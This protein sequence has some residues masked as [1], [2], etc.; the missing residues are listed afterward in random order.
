MYCLM[1]VI[2]F[3]VESV[4]DRKRRALEKQRQENGKAAH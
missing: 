3:I 4:Y 2:T 1:G